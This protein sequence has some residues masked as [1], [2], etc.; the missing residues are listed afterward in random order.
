MQQTQRNSGKVIW[1][2]EKLSSSAR[3]KKLQLFSRSK[4]KRS[5]DYDVLKSSQGENIWLSNNPLWKDKTKTELKQ[6]EI[7]IHALCLI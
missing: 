7:Q 3:L 4:I 5:F 6:D 1:E 2:L